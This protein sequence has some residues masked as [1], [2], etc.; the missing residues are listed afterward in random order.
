M[1]VTTIKTHKIKPGQNLQ[2]ILDAYLL[3]PTTNSIVAISS[4]AVSIC[5]NNLISKNTK[6][7]DLVHQEADFC[8][9]APT[10]YPDFCL[11]LKNQRLIPNAGIDASNHKTYVLLP[12]KPQL[13]AKKIWQYLRKKHNLKNLGIIITDSNI[14]PLRSG[15]TGITIGWCGFKPIYSYVG[16]KDIFGQPMQMTKINLLDSLATMATLA[17]GEGAEQTPLAII[18]NV[19]KINFLNRPPT[20]QEEQTTYL[21]KKYDLFSTAINLHSTYLAGAKKH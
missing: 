6:K 8:F 7:R 11:T 17:M 4:K 1:L 16:K 10:Q 3:K 20:K 9:A 19:L 5:E 13:T 15:V 18:K 12:A 14:T 2:A 21:E